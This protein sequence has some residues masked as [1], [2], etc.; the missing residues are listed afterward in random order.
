MISAVGEWRW[1]VLQQWLVKG[2]AGAVEMSV[3]GVSMSSIPLL[4]HSVSFFVNRGPF[5]HKELVKTFQ[6]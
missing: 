2:G 1:L 4:F 5:E 6:F 3:F